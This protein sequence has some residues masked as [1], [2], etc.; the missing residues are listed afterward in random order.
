MAWN[1]FNGSVSLPQFLLHA[2]LEIR[3]AGSNRP[4]VTH[5]T[6]FLIKPTIRQYVDYDRLAHHG[7]CGCRNGLAYA[8]RKSASKELVIA[9]VGLLCPSDT[10]HL[11]RLWVAMGIV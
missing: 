1:G 6:W 11:G 2:F 3:A 4:A 9:Y 5:A 8:A 7:R 10:F